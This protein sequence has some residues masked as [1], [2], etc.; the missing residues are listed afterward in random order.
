M[1]K[2]QAQVLVTYIIDAE[3]IGDAMEIVE[4]H[5]EFPVVPYEA[6]HSISDELLSIERVVVQ[7]EED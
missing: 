1:A 4:L 7:G 2:Y 3:N 5:T 6:G